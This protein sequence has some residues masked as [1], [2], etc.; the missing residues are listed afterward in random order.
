MFDLESLMFDLDSY[1]I[2]FEFCFLKLMALYR[3][4]SP[5]DTLFNCICLL[6][7]YVYEFVH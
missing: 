6:I 7:A 1:F 2:K 3:V 5:Q 4:C